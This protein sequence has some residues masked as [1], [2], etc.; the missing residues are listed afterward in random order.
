MR[1]GTISGRDRYQVR[2][3]K[4]GRLDIPIISIVDDDASQ[5]IATA[6][7]L[8]SMGFAAYVFASAREFLLSPRLS[9]TCCLI[10]DVEMPGMS[11]LKLQ[12]ELIAQ[13]NTTPVMFMTAFPEDRIRDQAMRAGAIGFLAK[14][15][16]ETQLLECVERALARHGT[17]KGRGDA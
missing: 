12:E 8:R 16:D 11:G 2:I 10:A 9:D 7:L 6:R 15:F 1:G 5:R 3:R 17:G 14:P 13:G 4:G